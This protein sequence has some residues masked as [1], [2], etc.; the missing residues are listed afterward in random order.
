MLLLLRGRGGGGGSVDPGHGDP[1]AGGAHQVDGLLQV[2]DGLIDLV[3]DDGLVEVVGVGLLQDL[4]L[5][6][7][8]LERLVLEEEEDH[9][10]LERVMKGTYRTEREV[11]EARRAHGV[12]ALF[13]TGNA[14]K[15][16]A[17]DPER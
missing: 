9:R 10:V 3:V 7:Q 12:A 14:V 6:L 4:G 1:L 15:P 2:P 11:R 17:L 13:Q 8:S 5:L 16:L